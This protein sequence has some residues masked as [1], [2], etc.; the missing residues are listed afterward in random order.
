MNWSHLWT[1]VKQFVCRR[2][3]GG[4]F[5]F[6]ISSDVYVHLMRVQTSKEK[7]LGGG[8]VA[9]EITKEQPKA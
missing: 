5:V 7:V 6:I 1:Q 2:P 3:Q 9:S 4:S 8:L